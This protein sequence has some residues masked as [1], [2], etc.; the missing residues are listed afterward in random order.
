MFKPNCAILVPSR[1]TCPPPPLQNVQ[2]VLESSLASRSIGAGD[3]CPKACSLVA[4]LR[5]CGFVPPVNRL[6]GMAYFYYA[7]LTV[8]AIYARSVD[9]MFERKIIFVAIIIIIIIIKLRRF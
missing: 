1:G 7:I 8:C 4:R 2:T 6:L 5:T 9:Q 3:P